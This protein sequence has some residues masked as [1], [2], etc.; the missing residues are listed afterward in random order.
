MSSLTEIQDRFRRFGP[1]QAAGPFGSPLYVVLCAGLADDADTASLLLNSAPSQ[2]IPNLL[3]AAVHDLLLGGGEAARHPLARYYATIVSDPAPPDDDAYPAFRAFCAAFRGA[4]LHR[5]RTR[6]TQTNEPRR[7]AVLFPAIGLI[8]GGS[9]L[10]VALLEAG[11]SAG[12]LLQPE[13]Y[14]Y[15]YGDRRAGDPA[16]PLQLGCEPL[17]PL[18]PPIHSQVA[19]A[20]RAGLDLAPVDVNDAIAVR[21]LFAC[22]WPEHLERAA[23]LR[24]AIE[25]ARGAP[26]R[27]VRG[28]LV[29]DLAPLIA[30]A[31]E[32]AALVVMHATAL[33][34][35]MERRSR[36]FVDVVERAAHRLRRPIWL[37]SFETAGILGRIDD[38]LGRVPAEQVPTGPWAGLALSTFQQ[39]GTH[40]HR[41]LALAHP[42]GRW[43]RW[44]DAASG[45]PSGDG[46]PRIGPDA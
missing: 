23:D 7:A 43:L 39:N 14:G 41:L 28:D 44:L 22:L 25:L 15:A 27:I 33:L 35:L 37:L 5:I 16:S 3:L 46:E 30:G 2:Q 1:E 42:H 4:L 40:D 38:E 29:D 12:L 36:R 19:I 31:P 10:P 13:R 26:P 24:S 32:D 8:S 18:D 45:T 11:A 34:Y 17:P 9:G 6:S 21:W 20:W